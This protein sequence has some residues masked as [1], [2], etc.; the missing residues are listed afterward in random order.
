MFERIKYRAKG[1]LRKLLS[2][3]YRGYCRYKWRY[4]NKHNFTKMGEVFSIGKVS[5]DKYTYGVLN[6]REYGKK[7]IGSIKI[8]AFCSIAN[9]SEFL[10]GGEH[11]LDTISTYPFK[12]MVFLKE[13]SL[14]KGKIIVKDDVWIGEHAIILSGVTIGQGAVIAAGTV[15]AK[16]VPAYAIVAGNPAKI[17]RYRFGTDIVER[18]L[19]IDYKKID[20]SWIENNLEELY[21]SVSE[22]LL[23]TLDIV[24]HKGENS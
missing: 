21:E 17:L 19:R 12:R 6:I 13:E 4:N 3:P 24:S 8:G 7:S 5:V 20:K 16:D 10:L 14:S 1:Y 2:F 11:Y 18:L 9:T 23:G 15:V 22:D